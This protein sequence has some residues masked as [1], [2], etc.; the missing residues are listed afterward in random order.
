MKDEFFP[1]TDKNQL[2]V[3]GY[4]SSH[5]SHS[6]GSTVD[7]GLVPSAVHTPPSFDVAMPLV[8][9]TA[10]KGVRF[11]DGTIDF[12]TGYDCLDPLAS[13][14][15]PSVSREARLNRFLLQ[16]VMQ[17]HGF[18]PNSREWWHFRFANDSATAQS[19]DFPIVARHRNDPLGQG[20]PGKPDQQRKTRETSMVQRRVE[21][22]AAPMRLSS[23]AFTCSNL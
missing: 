5:S 4:L 11:D 18:T 22:D 9:C 8:P 12:G 2:F 10:P 14:D 7:V 15:N 19:F 3:L 6:R 16:R 20:Y 17:Q 23:R 21:V 13:A 1:R